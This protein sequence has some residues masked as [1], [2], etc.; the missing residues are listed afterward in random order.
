M[1]LD[2][3]G[4]GQTLPRARLIPTSGVL[5][6]VAE[7]PAVRLPCGIDDDAVGLAA[8]ESDVASVALIEG[9]KRRR[10]CRRP[11]TRREECGF[12]VMLL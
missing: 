9:G 6:H 10:G 11:F 7:F 1:E 12:H 4:L 8:C 5:K 2:G 3:D